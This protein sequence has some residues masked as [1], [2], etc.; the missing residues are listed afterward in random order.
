MYD[1]H[2]G[3]GGGYQSL[4][5]LPRQPASERGLIYSAGEFACGP[6]SC[7]VPGLG[8]G[9]AC[10]E[11]S[12]KTTAVNWKYVGGGR[13]GYEKMV[14]MRYVGVGSG[15]Y[16]YDKQAAAG[17]SLCCSITAVLGLLLVASVGFWVYLGSPNFIGL[18]F[19]TIFTEDS[20]AATKEHKAHASAQVRPE[21]FEYDCVVGTHG[22]ADWNLDRRVYCCSKFSVEC[23]APLPKGEGFPVPVADLPANDEEVSFD[24]R[25]GVTTWE[26][27]WSEAKK[28]WCCGKHGIGCLPVADELRKPSSTEAHVARDLG[29]STTH[30][31]STTA[32]FMHAPH[33]CTRPDDLERWPTSKKEWCCKAKQVGCAPFDCE[34]GVVVQSEAG[35]E[36]AQW[37]TEKRTWC[38]S[39]KEVGCIAAA[40]SA[41]DE[42]AVVIYA[43]HAGLTHWETGWSDAKKQWCCENEELG[44][45][46][47]V[48]EAHHCS[49]EPTSSPWSSKQRQWCCKHK[50]LGCTSVSIDAAAPSTETVSY[51]CD[52]GFDNYR[53]G[54]SVAKKLSCCKQAGRACVTSDT[55]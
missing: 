3:Q 11:P 14:S 54:W 50:S 7:A 26:S 43:C 28:R 4:N 30:P 41:A 31:P 33:D 46:R 13:G 6:S 34:D 22:V 45:I 23:N 5:V 16:D 39:R 55:P 24:C 29:G 17:W 15:G 18:D 52:A 25:A 51:D 2:P 38:C 40:A 44:C 27:G 47:E 10:L 1:G 20:S 21:A 48:A 9:D 49:L 35:V 19:S 32:A 36:I 37:S 42:Q 12:A 53:A 8:L